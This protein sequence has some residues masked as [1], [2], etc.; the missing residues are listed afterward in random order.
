MRSLKYGR[1]GVTMGV[2]VMGLEKLKEK[3][4]NYSKAVAVG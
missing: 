4:F 1:V 2:V 3:F